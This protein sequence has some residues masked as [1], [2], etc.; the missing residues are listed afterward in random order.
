MI[1]FSQLLPLPDACIYQ[2]E[3]TEQTVLL[4]VHLETQGALCPLCRQEATRVQS[5]YTRTLQD[6]PW[7]GRVLRLRVQVRRFSSE[8]YHSGGRRCL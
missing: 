8:K 7:A 3:I 5:H 2:I 4:S 1:P 6:L